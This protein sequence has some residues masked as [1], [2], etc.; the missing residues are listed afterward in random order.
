[1]PNNLSIKVLGDCDQGVIDVFK[2]FSGETRTIKFQIY[3]TENN[4]RV[5]IPATAV[6]TLILPSSG[7][8]D[9]TIIA[10]TLVQSTEC[11]SVYSAA[12]TPA[13]TTLLIS[14][15]IKFSFV[16]GS[17]PTAVTRMA[18]REAGIQKQSGA[19]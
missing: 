13:Q 4:Q 6:C 14:G 2:C 3:D 11:L 19:A 1:M 17:G 9:I 8:T 15:W 16:T 18:Y 12:L 10:P 5:C 7:T